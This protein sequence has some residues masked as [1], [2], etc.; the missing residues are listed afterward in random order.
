MLEFEFAQCA[1]IT[2]N[3]DIYYIIFVS[4]LRRPCLFLI[5]IQFF[6]I[7]NEIYRN[8]HAKKRN[9]LLLLR[10][11]QNSI[12]EQLLSVKYSDTKTSLFIKVFDGSF[13][14]CFVSVWYVG[15]KEWARPYDGTFLSVKIP[16][17]NISVS[18]KVSNG[19]YGIYNSS[20]VSVW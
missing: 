17:T 8:L 3:T 1:L 9:S 11:A 5:R 4:Y 2:N 15:I 14:W 16:D 10:I 12:M 19:I 18:F 13:R 7:H 6:L 20:I